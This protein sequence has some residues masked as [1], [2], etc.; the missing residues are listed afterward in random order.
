LRID[1]PTSGA[2]V[3]GNARVRGF[4]PGFLNV[5]VWDPTHQNPPLG[6][7]TPGSSG[8]FSLTVDTTKLPNGTAQWTVHGWDSAPGGDFTEEDAVTLTV[9]VQN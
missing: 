2:T 1:E 6:Q 4:G 5:E 8:A 9:N 7:A 3:S